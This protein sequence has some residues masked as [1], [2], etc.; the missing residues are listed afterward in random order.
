MAGPAI[1]IRFDIEELAPKVLLDAANEG[2]EHRIV[3]WVRNQHELAV[4]VQR[5]I[6]AAEEARAA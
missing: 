6:D 2:E 3:D 5:A 4:I 1:V